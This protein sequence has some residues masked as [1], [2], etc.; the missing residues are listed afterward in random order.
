MGLEG[1]GGAGVEK[2]VQCRTY[3]GVANLIVF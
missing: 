3:H 2:G 1:V